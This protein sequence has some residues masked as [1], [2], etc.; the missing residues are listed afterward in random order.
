MTDVEVNPLA[1]PNLPMP[2]WLQAGSYSANQ[3]R[4]VIEAVWPTS[5]VLAGMAVGARG[6]GANMSVDIAA[7]SAVVHGT[8]I[9]NQGNYLCRLLAT[10]NV[11]VGAAP[12]VGLTRIDLVVV[13]VTDPTATGTGTAGWTVVVVPGTPASSPSPPAVPA[14]S[15]PLAQVRVPNGTAQI[16]AAQITD[17]RFFLQQLAKPARARG[18]Q[19]IGMNAPSNTPTTLATLAL[20]PITYPCTLVVRA[21]G[22]YGFSTGVSSTDIVIADGATIILVPAT[23]LTLR[24]DTASNWYGFAAYATAVYSAGAAPNV[25]VAATS[26]G[27][28]C[29]F[30]FALEWELIAT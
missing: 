30:Q 14:S 20:P 28:N 11:V 22:Q 2:D 19:G 16:T 21:M 7:G 26:A 3:D 25:T 23:K 18:V 15:T 13:Q 1:D 5:G 24:F 29:N 10:T 17:T 27:V 12:G 6:A 8:D 4:Y 9:A